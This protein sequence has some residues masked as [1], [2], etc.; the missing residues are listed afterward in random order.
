[1]RF[2]DIH[3]FLKPIIEKD[4]YVNI[5]D[6]VDET[7]SYSVTV[8]C[9]S[10]LRTGKTV[11]IDGNSYIVT[12]INGNILSLSGTIVP[13]GSLLKLP[14]VYYWHGT[15]KQ[16]D[17]ERINIPNSKD[18]T[19]FV[20]LV[21]VLR[22]DYGAEDSANVE[23]PLRLFVLDESSFEDYTTELFY[24]EVIYPMR[25]LAQEI[26]NEIQLQALE[27]GGITAIN[28]TRF[29]TFLDKNGYEKSLFSEHLSGVE[30]NLDTSLPQRTDCL[31]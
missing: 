1:M 9:L 2:F 30:I 12:A 19:P 23:M 21:E 15:V 28:H 31:C 17:N 5:L 24:N 6:I 11:T 22:E 13:V 25:T 10:Y 8:D 16:T 4:R 18:K 27:V 29:A 7:T 14:S 20:Y 3:K 26:I